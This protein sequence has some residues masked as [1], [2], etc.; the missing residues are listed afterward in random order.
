VYLVL[1]RHKRCKNLVLQRHNIP[2]RAT[3]TQASMMAITSGRPPGG[4]CPSLFSTA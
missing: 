3:I 4:H 1:Q 2:R